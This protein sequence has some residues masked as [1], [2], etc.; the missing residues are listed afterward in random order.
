[1]R[2]MMVKS[3]SHINRLLPNF[4]LHCAKKISSAEIY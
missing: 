1:L 4:M 2:P 3:P